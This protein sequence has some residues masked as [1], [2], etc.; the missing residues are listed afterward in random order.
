MAS[1]QRFFSQPITRNF[2]TT[3]NTNEGGYGVALFNQSDLDDWV[4]E[5]GSKI[6]KIGSMYIVNGTASG[7]TLEDVVEGNNGATSLDATNT[8]ITDRRSLKDMGKEISIGTSANSRLLVLRKV[9]VYNDSYVAG[10]TEETFIGYVTVE[11]NTEDIGNSN[12]GRF[13]VKVARV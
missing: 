5:N 3:V 8:P 11:N 2:I 10:N 9:L 4:E 12:T 13:I 7:F 6:E 1:T